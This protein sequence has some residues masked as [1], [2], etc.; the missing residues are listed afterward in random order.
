MKIFIK[1][2]KLKNYNK[3]QI[4]KTGDHWVDSSFLVAI[5]KTT[6]TRHHA[7]HV[8]VGSIHVDRGGGVG[9]HSVVGHREEES[10]V[11]DTGQVA[12][13]AGLVL[14][15]LESKGVDVDTDGGDVGVVLV[16]LDLVEVATLANLEAIVT[17]ELEES[18]D[19]RVATSHTL[20]TGDG[21]AR[22]EDRAVPPVRE[23]EGLL[24]LPGV[25][26][27]ISAVNEGITLDNP[28]KLL[29]GVVEVELELVGRRGDGLTASELE[30]VDEVLV[31][32]LGE[33]AALISV[34][35]D[36]V[37]VEGGSHQVGVG[38]AVAD[39]VDVGE[40]RSGLP[41]EVTE[42][43]EDQIDA[44]L[45]VLEGDQRKSKTRVAAEP[46]LE[47]DVE[48]VLRG[49]LAD[50]VGAVGL[51]S[52]A[53]IIAILA[54]LGD[55]VGELGNVTNHL[56]VT[57]LLARLL[58]ELIPDVEPLTIM[59]ID[60]LTAD[61]E[62][63]LLDE[64]VTRPVQPTELGTRAIRSGDGHL[65]EGSL[66]VHA[67]DQV[68]V[69]LDSAGNSL[70][71][72]RGTV[73]GVLDGLHGEVSVATVNRL[74]E[75]NLRVSSQVDVLGAISDELHQTT[76]CHFS[77]YPMGRKKFENSRKFELWKLFRKVQQ[78]L[79]RETLFFPKERRLI[80]K[81]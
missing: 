37:H 70:A 73:E 24:T 63:N 50:L 33:L 8:V 18:G 71:K 49:A 75:S 25:D 72:A 35:V 41:A 9:A 11:V 28:H 61:L 23:V 58:G 16:R 36:V 20:N 56:G 13:A 59:L 52:N 15:R 57:S 60:T 62:L 46:E 54:T 12:G 51:T 74:E 78:I 80:W 5:S 76:T 42:I 32:D 2:I 30:N 40:L 34:E 39:G 31:R 6:H 14:L 1:F 21:V 67:V 3:N 53:V 10:G 44:H 22:L 4:A 45:V 29:A 68:T 55:Q 17:V 7:E 47:G 69:T 43:I 48:S 65:R 64:V 77:L 66:E 26:D 79:C 38:D 27:G 81:T 19:N